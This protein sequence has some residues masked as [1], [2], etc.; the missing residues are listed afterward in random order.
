MIP[1]VLED[2]PP[3]AGER[4]KMHGSLLSHT[5]YLEVSSLQHFK[6]GPES[7][8]GSQPRRG[9]ASETERG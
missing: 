8:T 4:L 6:E 7:V 2:L 5:S 1:A 3:K 9:L